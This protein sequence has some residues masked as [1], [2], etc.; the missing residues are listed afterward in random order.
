MNKKVDKSH[1]FLRNLKAQGLSLNTIIVA[2]I[3][4]IVLIVLWAIFTGK[5]GSFAQGLGGTT[6]SGQSC[7]NRC[8]ATGLYSGATYTIAT[9]SATACS[10]RQMG[11]VK[12]NSDEFKCCCTKTTAS[13][14]SCNGETCS[15][16]QTCDGTNLGDSSKYNIPAGSICCSTTCAG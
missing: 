4:L 16:T 15:G 13:L 3:V 8:E 5:M 10:D 14:P 1:K 7:V 2:A 6:E 9:S 11:T 12:I